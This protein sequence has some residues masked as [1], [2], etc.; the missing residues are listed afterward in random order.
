MPSIYVKKPKPL[1]WDLKDTHIQV[2][3]TQGEKDQYARK[4]KAAKQR[5]VAAW[6][7]WKLAN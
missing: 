6:I 7:R 3:V 5:S 2:R 1:D 4:A